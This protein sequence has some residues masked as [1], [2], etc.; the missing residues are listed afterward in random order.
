MNALF[1]H[2]KY[3]KGIGLSNEWIPD[4]IPESS[5]YGNGPRISGRI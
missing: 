4:S 2:L 3:F 5:Y 1:V